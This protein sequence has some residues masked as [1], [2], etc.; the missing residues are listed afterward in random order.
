MGLIFL[1]ISLSLCSVILESDP[2]Q[3]I[4]KVNFR[5]RVILHPPPYSHLL[6]APLPILCPS[7]LPYVWAKGTQAPLAEATTGLMHFWRGAA[8]WRDVSQ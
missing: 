1:L 2:Q 5:V 4:Q 3:V 7:C 8:V 6:Q